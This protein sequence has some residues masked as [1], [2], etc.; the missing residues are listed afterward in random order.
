MVQRGC[1]LLPDILKLAGGEVSGS[2]RPRPS[3][4]KQSGVHVLM[5]S[6]PLISPTWWARATLLFLDSSLT[7]S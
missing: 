6:L 1:D 5:G 2:Q 4:S 3:G 7:V